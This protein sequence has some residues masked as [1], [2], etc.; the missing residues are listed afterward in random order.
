[1]QDSAATPNSDPDPEGW[2]LPGPRPSPPAAPQPPGLTRFLVESSLS[3]GTSREALL[4]A[5]HT[6][7]RERDY[8][9][10]ARDLQCAEYEEKLSQLRAYAQEMEELVAREHASFEQQIDALKS[11]LRAQQ[12][13]AQELNRVRDELREDRDAWRARANRS[14]A[15]RILRTLAGYQRRDRSAPDSSSDAS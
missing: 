7:L 14:L 6:L 8:L 2:P 10:G 4:D 13:H 15:V 3:A 9:R 1:M 11:E 12:A 5:V